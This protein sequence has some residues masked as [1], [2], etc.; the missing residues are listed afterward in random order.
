L[1]NSQKAIC[2]LFVQVFGGLPVPRVPAE[3]QNGTGAEVIGGT[4]KV[5]NEK[6][7]DVTNEFLK[8]AYETLRVAKTL[9]AKAVLLTEKS[10]SCGCGK[11]FDGTFSNRFITGDGVTA[12][13][14]K[15]NGI[16]V[17]SV[18]VT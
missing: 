8:G 17:T 7:T 11:I 6:G 12:A 3:I 14:L 10:P 18:E 15:K 2:F 1:R 16:K 13:L 9:G 5:V 4:A